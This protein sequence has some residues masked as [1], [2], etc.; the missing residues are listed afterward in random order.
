[1]TTSTF[2][3]APRGRSDVSPNQLN[4]RQRRQT[5]AFCRSTQRIDETAAGPETTCVRGAMHASDA[6]EPLALPAHM[7]AALPG[8]W[9]A[10]PRTTANLVWSGRANNPRSF[11][12]HQTAAGACR[13]VAPV[14]RCSG[15]PWRAS[16]Q[17]IFL[18]LELP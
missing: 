7:H 13:D 9:G 1:V 8:R 6:D 5:T 3:V 18:L 15:S 2:A 14:R 11:P 16:A 12:A 4:V 10:P 17:H